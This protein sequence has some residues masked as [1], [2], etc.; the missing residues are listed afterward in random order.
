MRIYLDVCCLNRPFDDQTIPGNRLEAEAVLLILRHC[1]MGIFSWVTS[2]IVEF[3]I[4]QTTN[5]VRRKRLQILSA[6]AASRV[7]EKDSVSNRADELERLGISGLD[8]YHIAAAESGKAVI[9]LTTDDK[10]IRK[11]RRLSHEI[12]LRVVNPLTWIRE[13]ETT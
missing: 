1:E 3:E 2:D 12:H 6:Y 7:S 11:A 8:A 4:E 13:V 9:Y 5:T 10:L